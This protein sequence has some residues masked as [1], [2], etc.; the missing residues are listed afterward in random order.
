MCCV[1]G[2]L[3]MMSW[4]WVFW[5]MYLVFF[6]YLFRRYHCVLGLFHLNRSRC[7]IWLR[8]GPFWILETPSALCFSESFVSSSP[9]PLLFA[10]WVFWE[11]LA[12]DYNLEGQNLYA[13]A[14]FYKMNIISYVTFPKVWYCFLLFFL[15]KKNKQQQKTIETLYLSKRLP[16]NSFNITLAV[17]RIS[18]FKKIT[19]NI[20]F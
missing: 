1:L 19:I 5:I 2:F 3:E 17:W 15:L 7:L 18:Q 8:C 13:T 10:F 16:N 12:L 20:Y 9:R 14:N 6:I 11:R 4:Q